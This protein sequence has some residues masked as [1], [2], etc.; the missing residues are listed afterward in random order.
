MRE[1]LISLQ[2][3]ADIGIPMIALTFP[4]MLLLLIPV[5]LIEALLCKRWLGLT[6]RDAFRSN[7]IAN[8]ASTIIGVPIAWA[9]MFAV[10][11]GAFGVVD[12]FPTIENSKSPILYVISFV[13]TSA[14]LGPVGRHDAWIIPCA[15]LILLVPFFFASYGVEY[16]I[17]NRMLG[18]T[19]GDPSNLTSRRIRVAVRNSNLVTY[20]VMALATAVWLLSEFLHHN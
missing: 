1:T 4:T 7:T 3:V 9:I 2:L 17:I 6:A 18:M 20:G 11:M 5:I 19:E 16:L 13:L 15:V 8:L 14:W 10:E 12:R